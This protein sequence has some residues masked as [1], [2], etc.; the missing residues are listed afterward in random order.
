MMS[1]ARPNYGRHN[2]GYKWPKFLYMNPNSYNGI[3]GAGVRVCS[4]AYDKQ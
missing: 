4:A 1:K 3:S 2:K